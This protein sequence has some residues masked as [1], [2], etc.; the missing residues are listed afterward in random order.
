[1]AFEST[2]DTETT[3]HKPDSEEH[4]TPETEQ[5]RETSTVAAGTAETE[6]SGHTGPAETDSGTAEAATGSAPVATTPASTG[7]A[8]GVLAGAGAV[9]SAGLGLSSLTGNSLSEMLRSRK[10]IM[11]QIE[12]STGG[13]GGDQVEAAYGAPW[14]TVALVNGIF[15]LVALLV[16]GAVLAALARR[17][18]SQPWVKAISLG[19]AVLGVIGLAVAG[20]M[21]FDLFAAQPELPQ[22]P[23]PMPGAG[24]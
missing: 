18:D 21:Y 16:G 9:V 15:A 22:Q 6:V 20:G 11:G 8:G 19:G 24:G 4:E 23:A 10:E 17:A 12:A 2:T 3:D 7:R 13:G 14:H 5:A 1:M